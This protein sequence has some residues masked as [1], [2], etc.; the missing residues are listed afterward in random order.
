MGEKILLV[1]DEARVVSALQRSLYR[2]YQIEIAGGPQDALDAIAESNFAV[3]VSDLKMPGMSGTDFLAKVKAM[4]P[5]TVRILLTG[6]AD[7]EAAIAAVNEGNIFRL[8]TKPCPQNV[9][10][11]ALDD[12]LDRYRLQTSEQE[13]L[14]NTLM[15]VVTVLVEILGAVHPVAFGRAS[16]IRRYVRHLALELSPE[17]L[18]QFE[19]AAM[20]SQ[21]GCVSIPPEILNKQQ[22]G[23]PLFQQEQYDCRS[24]P[25]IG[26]NLVAM[27]PR[28]EAVA[29]MI[30]LQRD[31]RGSLAELPP[32]EYVVALG[33]QILRT[34]LDFDQRILGGA[35][36]EAALA[37]MRA[38]G[39]YDPV[40][41]EAFDC[42]QIALT[43]EAEPVLVH[44]KRFQDDA[45][46]L[47]SY[48]SITD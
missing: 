8:L 19:A 12:A 6:Y 42:D 45:Q 38:Q 46:E 31:E 28:M 9:L 29:E 18:W 10:T 7:V 13:L 48:R 15:G 2:S 25:A 33:G 20:L 36:P 43:P 40:V 47:E 34:A 14:Q 23:D 24:H 3:V 26:R 27:I 35:E 16:R 30:G 37:E 5:D 32:A 41:L 39:N 1:D 21:I 22:A 4:A 11:R 17:N 44:G